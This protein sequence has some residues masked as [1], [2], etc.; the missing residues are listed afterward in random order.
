MIIIGGDTDN[1]IDDILDLKTEK[2]CEIY[3]F[4]IK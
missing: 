2:N 4:D 3:I 1:D